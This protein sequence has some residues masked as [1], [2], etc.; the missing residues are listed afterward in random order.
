[1]S[2]ARL[3]LIEGLPGAGKSTTAHLMSLHMA[4]HGRP[5]RWFYEHQTPHPIFHYPDILA[6]IETGQ[7]ADELFASAP[8][9]WRAFAS[10]IAGSGES[11]FVESAFFQLPVHPMRLM[12]WSE[13]RIDRYLADVAAAIRVASPL[14]IV[15]R[16]DDVPAALEQTAHWRGDWFMGFLIRMIE[17]SAYGQ[18]RGAAGIAAVHEYFNSYRDQIDRCVAA[19]DI[20]SLVLDAG[21]AS[22]PQ[23]MAAIAARL[24]LERDVTFET[25]INVQPFVGKYG[26]AEGD[27]LFDIVAR[28]PDLFVNGDAPARL[29]HRGQQTFEIAGL[30]V[31]LTFVPDRTGRITGI[32][33][34][35]PLPNLSRAW[36]RT[37]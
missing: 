3:V 22:K 18:A 12:G 20:E 10:S 32:D 5:A 1:M 26:A 11:A 9:R 17:Q 29:I 28:G 35:G 19:L 16:H 15:L 36:A 7:A 27:G 34:A 4:R 6:A 13:S 24:G 33:C 14:L 8:D 21:V 30:P 2:S 37:E 25:G 23:T 31:S